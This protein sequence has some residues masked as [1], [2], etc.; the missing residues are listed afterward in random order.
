MYSQYPAHVGLEENL[1]MLGLGLSSESE[2]NSFCVVL[3]QLYVW[4]R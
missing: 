2:A 3:K 4:V 1:R